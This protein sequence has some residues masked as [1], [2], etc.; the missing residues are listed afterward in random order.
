[1]IIDK[2][3]LYD[4]DAE[5]YH[6]DPVVGG[7]LSASGA[8]LLVPPST[9]AHYRWAMDNKQPHKRHFDLGTAAHSLV[10]GDGPEPVAYPEDKLA[11]NGAASTKAAKEWADDMRTEGK[12]PLKQAEVDQ[13]HAM[14]DQLRRHPIA[15][16]LFTPG[17]GLPEQSMF[18]HD[19]A[20]GITRR[21]RFDWLPNP[22]P[23][24]RLIIPDYKTA[25]SAEPA[26]WVKS[27]TDFGVHMQH[28]NYVHGAK[29]LGLAGQVAFVFV[30]QE[31]TAPYLVSVIEVDPEGAAIGA[32]LMDLAARR[33]A[34]GQATGVWPGYGD[35]VHQV[36]LPTYYVQQIEG[37]LA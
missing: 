29:A 9:P 30:V 24:G 5:A 26:K 17:N 4:M 6:A 31:K 10:L 35:E 8:K 14:A 21:A 37:V 18:W 15:G 13:I 20:N 22:A 7:S 32:G 25:V 1:M 3:G 33:F 27:G 28:A 23:S 36:S 11:S 34:E 2:P 19:E 12:L 16:R